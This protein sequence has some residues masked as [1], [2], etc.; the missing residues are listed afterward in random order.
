MVD[1]IKYLKVWHK[2]KM[3]KE[4]INNVFVLCENYSL[5]IFTQQ[6]SVS[7]I[8]NIS[9]AF[10]SKN[11]EEISCFLYMAKNSCT[12]IYSKLIMSNEDAFIVSEIDNILIM[13]NDVLLSILE[14]IEIIEN[15]IPPLQKNISSNLF[16]LHNC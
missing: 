14:L 4:E 16:I 15:E 5:K 10:E 9:E 11:T 1:K 12:S 2:A 7:V 13:T 3:L 6:A 8:N